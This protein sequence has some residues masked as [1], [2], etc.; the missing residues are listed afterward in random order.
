[1]KF[2]YG[3]GNDAKVSYM[4]KVLYGLGIEIIGWK[5][6]ALELPDVHENGSD[7]LENA[8]T[9]ASAYHAACRSPVFSCDSGL[10]I[11]GLPDELQPGVNVRTVNGKRLTDDEM[12]AHYSELALR[13]G[14][15]AVARYRN[16]ICLLD[17]RGNKYT[18]CGDDIAS[19]RFILMSE[20]HRKRNAGFPLDSLSVEIRTGR[21]Y[22]DLNEQGHIDTDHTEEEGFRNFFRGVMNQ[23]YQNREA[24]YEDT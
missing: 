23:L 2:I 8:C 14:G 15:Q 13:A 21:Y 22:Y 11:E 4:Q 6:T 10:T 1:M 17:E 12:I 3:T 9:K 20:P 19:E 5:D 16:A 18:H 24:E 7:P